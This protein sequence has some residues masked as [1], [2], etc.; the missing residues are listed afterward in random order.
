MGRIARVV[1]HTDGSHE[2]WGWNVYVRFEVCFWDYAN[3][4]AILCT[5][6]T[7]RPFGVT[8]RVWRSELGRCTAELLQER[9]Y[10][11]SSGFIE[12]SV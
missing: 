9:K 5:F 10:I 6:H 2:L 8:A 4:S 12:G 7:P 11:Y 1:T 3:P